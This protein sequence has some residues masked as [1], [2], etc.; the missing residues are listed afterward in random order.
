MQLS[1]RSSSEAGALDETAPSLESAANSPRQASETAAAQRPPVGDIHG[2]GEGPFSLETFK[3]NVA[4]SAGE[5]PSGGGCH[6]V[7]QSAESADAKKDGP[8]LHTFLLE[9]VTGD[10]DAA[11]R[12]MA[13]L[14][15]LYF[16]ASDGAAAVGCSAPSAEW[17]SVCSSR[18]EED[19]P[20]TTMSRE[21]ADATSAVALRELALLPQDEGFLLAVA[22]RI[23][24]LTASLE[25]VRRLSFRGVWHRLWLLTCL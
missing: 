18:N 9:K 22:S 19:L 25:Q 6:G 7:G 8:S 5:A 2:C 14:P 13:S 15:S 16:D 3:E 24:S 23:S 20:P 11:A 4:S 1:A 21:E 17:K 10:A 12:L